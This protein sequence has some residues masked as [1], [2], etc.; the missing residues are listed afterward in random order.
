MLKLS[1]VENTVGNTGSRISAWHNRSCPGVSRAV[2]NAFPKLESA[3]STVDLFDTQRCRVK[4]SAL[5][6]DHAAS[7]YSCSAGGI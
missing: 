6:G 1:T 7:E 2:G 5:V 4:S 3:L